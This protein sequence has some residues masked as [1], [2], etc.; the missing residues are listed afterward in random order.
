LDISGAFPNTVIPVLIHNMRRK[1][2][3]VEITDWI[4]RLN[5]GRTTI[6]SFDGFLSAIFE[7]YSGLDQGN[8]LSMILYCF[9]AMDLLKN[10]GKKD[11]LSTSFVDDTTFL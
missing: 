9:Y 2:V 5:K 3:P 6:L 1:G 11:E 10:F 4:R 8:P 7:V